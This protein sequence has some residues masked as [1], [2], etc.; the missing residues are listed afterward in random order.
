MSP[1]KNRGLKSDDH[2]GHSIA[3]RR[4]I[5]QPGIDTLVMWRCFIMLEYQFPFSICGVALYDKYILFRFFIIFVIM[6]FDIKT[7]L[8]TPHKISSKWHVKKAKILCQY[9][10][11]SWLDISIP[12]CYES[13]LS[14]IP[15]QSIN[16][17]PK[18]E[19]SEFS[20]H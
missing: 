3:P 6:T 19:A 4:P 11:S 13:K 10:C 16:T 1:Y 9:R 17:S 5:Q 15:P 2:G 14:I 8:E 12:K 20:I 18:Q 7:Q